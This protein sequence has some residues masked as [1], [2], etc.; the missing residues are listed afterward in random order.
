[1]CAVCAAL[2]GWSGALAEG[3]E[4]SVSDVSF[5]ANLDG[6]T[7]KYVLV[8]PAGFRE[9]VPHDVLIALHGHG[10][11]RWQ[12]VKDSRDECRAARDV[13]ARHDMVFLSPDY[14]ATTSW[15]GPAAESDLVQI[16]ALVRKQHKIS[17][18]ILCGGSMGGTASLSF[19]AMH[20]ELIDGVAAMNG[21]ANLLEYDNF[22]DAIRASFGGTK[23]EI[24]LQ[25][26]LRSAEYWPE[27][28]TMPVAMTASGKDAVVPPQSVRRLA[29]VLQAL[30]HPVKLIYR[31]ELG[32]VTNYD[33]AVEILAFAISHAAPAT[34]VNTQGAGK[35]G[36]K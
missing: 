29:K 1:L 15:M 2:L 9:D 28:L 35:Q 27:K 16:I 5:A 30:G 34:D 33:D 3:Q 11:D 8:L 10:A 23:A 31:E 18:V 32:H 14:R 6:T 26:K 13:A 4:G 36:V 25:Y 22:S 20:P 7:Q 21:T 19:A 12:F 17:R 24:P